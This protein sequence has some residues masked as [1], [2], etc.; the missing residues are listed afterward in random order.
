M[1]NLNRCGVFIS[2][3]IIGSFTISSCKQKDEKSLIHYDELSDQEKRLPQNAMASMN[4]AKNLK[5][6]LFSSE[7]TITNPTNMAIDANGRIWICEGR[8][9]RNFRNPKNPYE[10]KGDRIMI[11]EDTNQDGVAD[12]S[13][14]F[15]QGE[16]INSALG[17]L[18]LGN[19]VIV[20][21]SPNIF[22]F[23]D[24]DGDDVPDSKE[25]MFS[26]IA[27]INHDH[28][29]H[30]F[31]FGPDG[32]LY[33]NYGNEAKHLL[34]K[35]GD[36]ILD[37]HGQ[38]IK[39]SGR[40]YWEGMVFRSELDGSNVEVLGH[41]FRNPYELA[42]DSYGG[43]WQSDNDDDGNRGVRINFLMEYGNYGFR[44]KITGAGWQKR[45]AGWSDSIPKR[46]W[47]QNDPGT[48]PNLLQTGSGSP[49]GMIVYEGDMLP[50]K[51]KNQLIHAEPGHNV[52]RSYIIENNGAGHKAHIENIITSKDNWFRPDDVAVAPD[53]SLF[54]SDWYD[55]G[56]GGHM[57]DDVARGRVYRLST[58]DNYIP[59]KLEL[60]TAEGAAKNLIS[61]NM[62]V[63]YQSWQ[64]LHSM[65]E[66]VEPYLSEL[67]KKDGIA[68]ARALWLGAKIP[69]KCLKYIDMALSDKD[70]K[71]RMQGIRMA[72]YVAI[73]KLTD[74]IVKVVNDSSAQVRREAAIALKYIGTKDA[75]RL[76]A[77]LAV[78]HQAGDRWELEALGIGADIYSD[79]YF[80]AWKNK[81]GDNWHN[82]AGK[83]IVWRVNAEATVPLLIKLIKDKNISPDII[84][85]YFRAFHFK[86][87]PKKNQ[88]L[89]S[90]L[91][92]NHP[93][94]KLIQTYAVGELDE[95]FVKNSSV[96]TRSVKKILP[97]IEG[98]PEWLRAIKNLKVKGQEKA[99]FQLTISDTDIEIR[100]EAAAMLFDVGG[101]NYVTEY[102]RSNGSDLS[103]L[104]LMDVL[105]GVGQGTAIDFLEKCLLENKFSTSLMRKVVESLGNTGNG[106][107]K[108]YDLLV[109]GMI[110]DEYKITAVLK[111]M[112]S[113]NDEIRKSAPNY[114]APIGENSIDILALEQKEGDADTGKLV[115]NTYCASC[116]VADG[117]GIDFGPGLS[118]IGNKLSKSFLYSSI[119]YPSAG[120]NFGY[121]GYNIKLKDGSALMGYIIGRSENTITLKMMGASI[122][123]ISLKDIENMEEMD[124]SLMPEG[125][126]RVMEEKDLINLVAYLETL[127]IQE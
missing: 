96:Y 90:L 54:I 2:I 31:I 71:F 108:L 93:H 66:L 126:D 64:K 65:G 48:V 5:M 120:I 61:P 53:G 28:G 10:K 100:K 118:D 109:N 44:D 95:A 102:F 20:S 107:A 119:V 4:V 51:F 117:A 36:T 11:L 76:W 57:A 17:I 81:V 22:V 88:L 121:E 33:F 103:K 9:Y 75:A 123:E 72:K 113:R 125:L 19:K 24:E 115:Y 111:L 30:A 16:D 86:T 6:N 74:F 105:G 29:A 15:Y 42:I 92:L 91:T 124:K 3:L 46:H 127:K 32:R 87:H 104:Q 67:I 40:P 58:M 73:D 114:L 7:P 122:K 99:L 60:S 116:H 84:P 97:H 1:S 68:K 41:N 18:V 78:Q 59:Y 35:E 89:L 69:S 34:S 79:L 94:R 38:K 21:V 112:T 12:T 23:T 110:K 8:N 98:T 52:V 70:P 13:K 63:F 56:V 47:H 39:N 82:Q 25:I 80:G 45:R 27:G 106:Q 55:G 37:I 62:D 85:S 83:D 14:V 43:L 26:G 49:C 101:S 50:G 77:D